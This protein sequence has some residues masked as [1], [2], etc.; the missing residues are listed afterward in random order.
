VTHPKS[1]PVDPLTHDPLPALGTTMAK[2]P[3]VATMLFTAASHGF[4]AIDGF[5]VFPMIRVRIRVRARKA[6][7]YR[8][9]AMAALT[10][11]GHE[12]S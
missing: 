9:L 5:L 7:S 12:S 6:L 10:Y 1:D 2:V 8:T 4:P 11:D 3:V